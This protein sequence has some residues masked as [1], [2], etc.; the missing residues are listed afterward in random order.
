MRA[1]PQDHLGLSVTRSFDG[2]ADYVRVGG[3][4]GLG[5]VRDLGLAARELIAA[6][7]KV[8]Y[9]DLTGVTLMSSTLVGFLMQIASAKGPDGP[10][11]LCRPTSSARLVI[12]RTG[13]DHLVEMRG[14][15]PVSWPEQATDR[16]SATA[17]LIGR[18]RSS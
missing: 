2:S 3:A 18:Q 10:V 6:N 14:D 13:L 5:E 17:E 15:L 7:A 12:G 1:Q 9:V 16:R 8:I 11:V 4:V